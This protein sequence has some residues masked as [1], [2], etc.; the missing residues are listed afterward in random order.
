MLDPWRQDDL[1]D[2]SQAIISGLVSLNDRFDQLMSLGEAFNIL[3][4]KSSASQSSRQGTL[5]TAA[6][7]KAVRIGLGDEDSAAQL[8]GGTEGSSQWQKLLSNLQSL[9][10]SNF[11]TFVPLKKRNDI[12]LTA[13][14]KR[15]VFV[16]RKA[17]T[18]PF[19]S[20]L[21]LSCAENLA[22]LLNLP[23]NDQFRSLPCRGIVETDEDALFVFDYPHPDCA[24][25]PRSLLDLFSMKHIPVFQSGFSS[26]F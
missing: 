22:V 20:K 26:L 5:A 19:R 16:E 23:K 11:E 1:F 24:K 2:S 17:L 9:K 8:N 15:K 13:Y 21:L 25:E 14:N 12:D 4:A 3:E 7:C 18:R 6:R 10:R